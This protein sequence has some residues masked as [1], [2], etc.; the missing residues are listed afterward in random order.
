MP[1]TAANPFTAWLPGVDLEKLPSDSVTWGAVTLRSSRV[2]PSGFRSA[3]SQ[4][5][6]QQQ[7]TLS[8]R[9]LAQIIHSIGCWAKAWRTPG[10]YW[11]QLALDW[12][13]LTSGFSSETVADGLDAVFAELQPELLRELVRRE[14]G[15]PPRGR[16]GPRLIV[17]WLAGHIPAVAV[18]S[19]VC[20]LL[21]KSAQLLKPSSHEPLFAPLLAA[22]WQEAD[23]E[24]AACVGALW[25]PGGQ[26]ELEAMVLA[27]ADMVVAY[28]DDETL[29]ELQA[30]TPS[31]ARFIGHGH[32][33]SFAFIGREELV[34]AKLHG[35]AAELA[36]D[37]TLYDQLGCLSPQVV[38]LER[39]ASV[40]PEEFARALGMALTALESRR[41][42]GRWGVET[43]AAIR[44][45][46]DSYHMRQLARESVEIYESTGTLAWTVIVDP[47]LLVEPT[48][49]PRVIRINPVDHL[50]DVVAQFLPWKGHLSTVG[51]SVSRRRVQT[52]MPVLSTLG[53]W[54]FC[55]LGRM[56]RPSLLESHDGRPLPRR[57]NI[58]G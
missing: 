32:Q 24:I 36:Q 15:T 12:I 16:G 19:F 11:R 25:W 52:L 54:R 50:E 47:R 10:F 49:L 33:W 26:S 17:H 3:L 23:P 42:A 44:G 40:S 6:T 21:A 37:V 5:V 30:R 13:P 9:P 51:I 56:Q 46:R 22:S 34:P 29:R 53:V 27:Q 38:C 14:V 1:L 31:Q 8:Q 28:G 18:M 4:M 7:Q 55:P 39:G 48:P 45:L 20:G 57:V 43:L 35:L 58:A 41:P 2:S